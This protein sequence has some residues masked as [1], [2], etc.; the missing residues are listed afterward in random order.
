MF[1]VYEC[2]EILTTRP[3]L[4]SLGWGWKGILSVV[5]LTGW[6]LYEPIM[7]KAILAGR[8]F[9]IFPR[10]RRTCGNGGRRCIYK[11]KSVDSLGGLASFNLCQRS[12]FIPLG[13]SWVA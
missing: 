10:V 6:R 8:R 4:A 5:A 11:L 7:T 3:E 1:R 12:L 13:S 2:R 9:R